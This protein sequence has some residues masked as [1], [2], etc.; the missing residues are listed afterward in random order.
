MLTKA[1]IKHMM[2]HSLFITVDQMDATINAHLERIQTWLPPS[3]MKVLDVLKQH[4]VKAVGVAYLK[5]ATIAE[6]VGVSR[7]TV[8]RAVRLLE[9]LGLIA[10][11]GTER[12]K[13]GGTGANMYQFLPCP[14]D[15]GQMMGRG[16]QESLTAPTDGQAV[17]EEKTLFLQDSK[18]TT[19]DKN[20]KEH[21]LGKCWDFVPRNVPSDFSAVVMPAFGD[22]QMVFKLWGRV[23]WFKQ[24]SD[25]QRDEN[26]LPMALEAWESTKQAYKR[27]RNEWNRDRFCRYFYGTLKKIYERHL[28]EWR[29]MWA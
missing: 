1:Q 10:R 23:R 8:E 5:I 16:D 4:A 18:A 19:K 20:V 26:V 27:D 7:A 28:S 6:A 24:F 11:I 14:D 13:T 9:K 25:F 17:S 3:T 21:Q 2:Q 12:P 15:G 22:G 29:E